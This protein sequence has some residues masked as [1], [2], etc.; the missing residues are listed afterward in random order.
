MPKVVPEY[1]EQ[2]RK[3]ILSIAAEVFAEMGYHEATMDD[4]ASRVGVSKG[5]V[6][7]YFESKDSLFRD[8]CMANAEDL[9]SSLRSA[10]TDADLQ[11]VA[12]EYMD[13]ELDRNPDR[14]LLMFEALAEAPRNRTVQERLRETNAVYVDIIKRFVDE[15]K[16]QRVLGDDVDSTSIARVIVALR[17]GVLASVLQGLDK[18]EAKKVWRDGLDAVLRGLVHPPGG[19]STPAKGHRP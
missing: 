11:R 8:L 13:Y 10:F 14:M 7:Q 5:A 1:R 6:Y 19:R 3:R 16:A 12:E 18:A 2:A 4:V 17:H 9:E 15:L